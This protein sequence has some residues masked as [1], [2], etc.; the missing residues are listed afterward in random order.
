MLKREYVIQMVHHYMV[1]HT[2]SEAVTYLTDFWLSGL[3]SHRLY[4]RIYNEVFG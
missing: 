3:L 2:R 4:E 1:D